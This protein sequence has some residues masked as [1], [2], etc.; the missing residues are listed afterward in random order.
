[1][2]DSLIVEIKAV[3]ELKSVYKAQSINYCEAYNIADGLLINLVIKAFNFIEYLIKR[4]K[5]SNIMVMMPSYK[6]CFDNLR[7]K[8]RNH[9]HH[10]T[11]SKQ[12]ILKSIG[13]IHHSKYR[14]FKK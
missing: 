9:V 3:E 12:I 14:Q 5:I 6:L 11:P 1:M 4:L 2:E 10:A 8:P 13:S 7:I